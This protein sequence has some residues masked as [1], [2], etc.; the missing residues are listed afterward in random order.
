ML[1]HLPRD[2]CV[3]D[4]PDRVAILAI[5]AWICLTG[6]QR[7]PRADF[8][9][10][11]GP[12]A[13]TIEP[14]ILTGQ[15][16]GRIAAALFEGLTRFDPR[17]GH[18]IPGLASSWEVSLDGRRYQFH[19]RTN[20]MWST[21]QPIRA[22]DFVWSWN[23]AV[24][25]ETGADY[26]GFFFYVRHGRECVGAAN[27]QNPAPLGV[28]A[29]DEHTVEVELENP[30]PFFPELCAMRVMAVVP[31][32][33]I[34]QHGDQW[35]RTAPVPCSGAYQLEYW[36]PNDRIRLRK[37][38]HYWDAAHVD[39][40]TV[41]MLPGDSPSTAINLFLTGAVDYVA[42]K[43]SIPTEL[44]DRVKDDSRF[45]RFNYLASYFIR[46]NTTRPPFSDPRVR[47][48]PSRLR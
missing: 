45:L 20:A 35:I 34:E 4:F 31:R 10:H 14:Q 41:D 37:N 9:I 13:E 47:A 46:I 33:W 44:Y 30:T 26:A 6:C 43:N 12:E 23:R 22:G 17:D 5:L 11:N 2:R 40:E 28:R 3:G 19:L 7:E 25:P 27:R 36:R 42:D 21:G 29:L 18:A 38:A 39:L 16:D 8:V 48:G 1:N 24:R 15:G 32:F